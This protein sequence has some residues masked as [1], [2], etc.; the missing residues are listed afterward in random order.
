[1]RP[2]RNGIAPGDTTTRKVL[3]TMLFYDTDL[4]PRP[5]AQ[6]RIAYLGSL[7]VCG[8][9][10]FTLGPASVTHCALSE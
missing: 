5:A 1:M 8:V 10:N 4:A 2:F 6:P 3:G 7:A 9:T